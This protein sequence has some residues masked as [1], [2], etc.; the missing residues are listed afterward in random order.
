[1]SFMRRPSLI[2]LFV[3]GQQSSV[4][5]LLA[6]PQCI[7]LTALRSWTPIGSHDV[8]ST[9]EGGVYPSS[10]EAATGSAQLVTGTQ[11]R[12]T[13]LPLLPLLDITVILVSTVNFASLLISLLDYF[14]GAIVS[15]G[16]MDF[17]IVGHSFIRRFQS[18]LVNIEMDSHAELFPESGHTVFAV[19][20]GGAKLT[21][22]T[23]NRLRTKL[24]PAFAGKR[25][26]VFLSLGSN[27]LAPG[28][29]PAD[30]AR[31]ILAWCLY[32]INALDARL[33][34]IDQ[35][36]PRDDTKFP[37]FCQ[38]ADDCNAHIHVRQLLASG[39]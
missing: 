36:L 6:V 19:S 26:V 15:V 8:L 11:R 12:R 2:K 39:E 21:G 31:R 13:I 37:G 29:P 20:V 10:R 5:W 24:H 22:E 30:V 9:S 32:F 27:D 3:A 1:M 33:V 7:F 34:I 25:D 4:G 17:L 38:R 35:V 28:V 16:N 18:F 14:C 23:A